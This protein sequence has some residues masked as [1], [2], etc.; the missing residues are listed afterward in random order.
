VSALTG[1]DYSE[2]V[3]AGTHLLEVVAPGYFFSPVRH[4]LKIH[5]FKV[6]SIVSCRAFCAGRSRG[7]YI[8]VIG[9]LIVLLTFRLTCRK[10]GDIICVTLSSYNIRSS[11]IFGDV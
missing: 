7:F 10:V 2:D 6:A 1:S 9:W 4:M 11:V 3:P 8:R 5:P